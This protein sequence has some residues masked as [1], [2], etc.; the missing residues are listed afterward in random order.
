MTLGR[1]PPGLEKR[2]LDPSLTAVGLKFVFQK[3][4]D[5]PRG[6]FDV[7]VVLE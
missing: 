2:A 3:T 4:R 1:V 7:T 6:A 5:S